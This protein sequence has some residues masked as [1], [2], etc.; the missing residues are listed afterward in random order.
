VKKFLNPPS[1]GVVHPDEN[2]NLLSNNFSS[3][4][5]WVFFFLVLLIAEVLLAE[6]QFELWRSR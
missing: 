4:M 2:R 6:G 3:Y 1:M 5:L